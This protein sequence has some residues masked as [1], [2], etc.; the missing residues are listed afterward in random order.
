MEVILNCCADSSESI[1]KANEEKKL[2]MRVQV[3]LKAKNL[4]NQAGLFQ[5]VSDPYAVIYRDG[6]FDPTNPEEGM[7]AR[8]ER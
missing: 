6:D 3:I 2:G 7:M 5:T 4:R 1:I 8:T